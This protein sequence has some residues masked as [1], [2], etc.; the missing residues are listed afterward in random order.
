M[1]DHR[2]IA[3]S[4]AWLDMSQHSVYSKDNGKKGS[5]SE[6]RFI[7]YLPIEMYVPTFNVTDYLLTAA[8]FM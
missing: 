3:Q 6:G 4:V 7:L 8:S 2:S 5:K 1:S